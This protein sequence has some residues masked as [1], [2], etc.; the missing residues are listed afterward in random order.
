MENKKFRYWV[1]LTVILIVINITLLVFLLMKPRPAEHQD[2]VN[3]ESIENY[4]VNELRLDEQQQQTFKGLRA[5]YI[6]REISLHDSLRA[7]KKEFFALADSNNMEKAEEYAWVIG[8]LESDRVMNTLQHLVD[9]K[10]ICRPDQQDVLKDIMQEIL[11]RM[12]PSPPRKEDGRKPRR[13]DIP[14]N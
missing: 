7:V 2:Q 4:L 3:R 14:Q 10:N 5:K 12:N 11:K 9:L 8:R 6:D 13:E 1:I